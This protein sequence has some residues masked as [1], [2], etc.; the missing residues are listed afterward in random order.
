MKK[1]IIVFVLLALSGA[2]FAQQAEKGSI[3]MYFFW[4]QGCSYCEEMKPFISEMQN[5]YPQLTVKSLETRNDPANNQ[6]FNDMARAYNK[7]AE[8]IP[9]TFIGS[10]MIEGYAKGQTDVEVKA[11]I[12]DCVK[13]GC[14]DPDRILAEYLKANPTTTSTTLPGFKPIGADPMTMGF[15]ALVVAALLVLIIKNRKQLM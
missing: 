15:A 8:G 5:A 10:K 2:C 12:D 6:L 11:A 14:P 9:G 1:A 7:T 4:G 3:T 13:N